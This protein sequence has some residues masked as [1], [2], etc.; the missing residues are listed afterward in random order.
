MKDTKYGSTWIEQ[1]K[2]TEQ[3]WLLIAPKLRGRFEKIDIEIAK[4]IV[5]YLCD[6]LEQSEQYCFQYSK[7]DA[8]RVIRFVKTELAAL[9]KRVSMMTG[10]RA[11]PRK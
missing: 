2:I 7:P 9:N 11:K 8:F 3:D 10:T 1:R 6:N 5:L 4:K